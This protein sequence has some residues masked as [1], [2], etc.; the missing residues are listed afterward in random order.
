MNK[1][2]MRRGKMDNLSTAEESRVMTYVEDVRT[3]V[4]GLIPKVALKDKS[5]FNELYNRFSQVVFNLAMRIVADRGEAEEIVQEVFFQIWDKASLYDSNRGAE[6]TWIINIARSRAID[7][8]RT[9]GFRKFNTEI[10]EEKINH[11]S[12]LASLIEQKDERKTIIQKALDS[13]PD[14]QRVAIEMVY[15]EGYTHYEIAEKLNQPV[16]TIKTRISLGVA[17]LR[18]QIAPYMKQLS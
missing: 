11:K 8:L 15:F 16:G 12:D 6:S 10:N 14:E 5:A 13:L 18:K 9:L 1:M 4:M 7:R 3:P 17:K 2:Q